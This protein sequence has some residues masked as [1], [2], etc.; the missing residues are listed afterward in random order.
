[1][2]KEEMH[3]EYYKPLRKKK[4]LLLIALICL[5]IVSNIY[6]F[7]QWNVTNDTINQ[8]NIEVTKLK[9]EVTSL[10]KTIETQAVTIKQLNDEN[11]Q[12]K[13]EIK[14]Y[15]LRNPESIEELKKFL[16]D[17]DVNFREYVKGYICINYARDLKIHA[18]RMGLNVSFIIVNFNSPEGGGGH[19]LNG[20]YLSNGEF[21]YIEPQTDKIY[22]SIEEALKDILGLE[23]VE[24][25]NYVILW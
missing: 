17:D 5:L 1:M 23:W 18:E 11:L 10:N 22:F 4:G 19:A 12:L 3:S 25:E 16:E 9:A 8:L 21:V 7:W 24:I 2:K 13:N 15:K 20:A 14:K 6:L